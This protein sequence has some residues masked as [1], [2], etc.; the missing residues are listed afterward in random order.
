[1]TTGEP[2][3][4]LLLTDPAGDGHSW[5]GHVEGPERVAGVVEGVRLGAEGAGAVVVEAGAPPASLELVATVHDPG[6]VGWLATTSQTGLLDADTYVAA[7]SGRAG[8]S[9]RP[10]HGSVSA[11]RSAKSPSRWECRRSEAD[12][13]LMGVSRARKRRYWAACLSSAKGGEA[14]LHPP[15][16]CIAPVAIHLLFTSI[17]AAPGCLAR[18]PKKREESCCVFAGR[19]GN[20]MNVGE[21]DQM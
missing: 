17:P 6:Y 20:I 21:R 19:C 11:M 14:R 18:F 2:P 3:I 12:G 16:H 7:G 10:T 13:S 9:A 15:I 4:V 1:M 8:S 5:P